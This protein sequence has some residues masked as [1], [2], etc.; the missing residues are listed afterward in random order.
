M[1][2]DPTGVA[3]FHRD[4]YVVLGRLFEPDEC[5]A[6]TAE[7]DSI[8]AAERQAIRASGGDPDE[9]LASG[10]LVGLALRSRRFAEWVGDPRLVAPLQAIWGEAVEYL[11]DKVVYKSDEVEFASPWHQDWWYWR[12]TNKISLWVAL[13]GATRENGCLLVLPGTHRAPLEPDRVTTREG[14]GL[15]CDPAARGIDVEP[16]AVE[17]PRGGAVLFS[18]L[19]LHASLPNRNGAPRRAWIPTYRNAAEPDLEYAWALA[20][21]RVG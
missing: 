18:D 6:I 9:A 19:T 3:S 2:T 15:R 7:V 10:V 21:R 20:R 17:L 12:G 1:M 13:D 14:F 4:G 11:S 8:L 16:V 5:D